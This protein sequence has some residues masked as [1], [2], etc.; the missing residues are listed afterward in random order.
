MI[1][2]KIEIF[3]IINKEGCKS[4][5]PGGMKMKRQVAAVLLAASVAASVFPAA[6]YAD[7]LDGKYIR[8]VP[9]SINAELDE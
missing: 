9:S 1:E 4:K 3:D 5:Y 6:A 8:L 2:F 7:G